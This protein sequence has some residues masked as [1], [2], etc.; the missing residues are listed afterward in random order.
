[1]HIVH[2]TLHSAVLIC[3]LYRL[4]IKYSVKNSSWTVNIV[5]CVQQYAQCEYT[6]HCI[7]YSIVYSVYCVQASIDMNSKHCAVCRSFVFVYLCICVFVHLCI[8]VFVYLCICVFVL[9]YLYFFICI[10][11][12]ICQHLHCPSSIQGRLPGTFIIM[13]S[14]QLLGLCACDHN[15]RS[16]SSMAPHTS[17]HYSLL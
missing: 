9:V 12:G 13:H 3:S 1:M 5:Y 10:S 17:V 8:C 11:I 7:V 16:A 14:W 6:M 15:K 4:C 2:Y